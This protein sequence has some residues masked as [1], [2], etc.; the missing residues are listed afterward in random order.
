ME[1][2]SSSSGIQYTFNNCT[3]L[4]TT[5]TTPYT[6]PLPLVNKAFPSLNNSISSLPRPNTNK[7]IIYGGN[8]LIPTTNNKS[9][10]T[11]SSKFF[12]FFH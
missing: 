9:I 1:Y 7:G 2:L 12:Q 5:T 10:L 11:R 3:H 4:I 6:T 8:Q